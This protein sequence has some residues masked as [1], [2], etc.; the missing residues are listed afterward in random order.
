MTLV[1]MFGEVTIQ[2]AYYHCKHCGR[3]W[4]PWRDKLRLSDG[5][6]TPAADEITA[7]AGVLGNLLPRPCW[8]DRS[9]VML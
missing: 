5:A 2:F 3:G 8:R 6:W 9:Q 7:L 1:S 4:R